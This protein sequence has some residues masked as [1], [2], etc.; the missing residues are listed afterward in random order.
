MSCT[1]P[2]K[3]AHQRS[4][5]FEQ[6]PRLVLLHDV[7][8]TTSSRCGDSSAHRFRLPFRPNRWRQEPHFPGGDVSPRSRRLGP[9]S[10]VATARLRTGSAERPQSAC[11][12]LVAAFPVG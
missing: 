11:S 7:T 1:G 9:L 6:L 10:V 3:T 2:E 4:R 5:Q 8:T 12:R